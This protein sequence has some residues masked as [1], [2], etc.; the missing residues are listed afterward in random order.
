MLSERKAQH[1]PPEHFVVR[2][3]LSREL[4]EAFFELSFCS[5]P[6]SC[7]SRAMSILPLWASNLASCFSGSWTE[8][9]WG[10][11]LRFKV[12]HIDFCYFL[13]ILLGMRPD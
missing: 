7:D 5:G 1:K 11:W 8:N 2:P 10:F 12:I 3:T 6:W 9:V 13:R 4:I